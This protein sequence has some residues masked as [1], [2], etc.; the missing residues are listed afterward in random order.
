M[1]DLSPFWQMVWANFFWFLATLVF[2]TIPLTVLGW[3]RLRRKKT[4][5]VVKKTAPHPQVVCFSRPLVKPGHC[6]FCGQAWPLEGPYPE[7]GEVR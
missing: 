2:I 4:A 5:R 3:L 6:P 1:E 7:E